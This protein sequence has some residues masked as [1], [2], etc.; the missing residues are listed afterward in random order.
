MS[1]H[2]N[3]PPEMQRL[4]LFVGDWTLAAGFGGEPSGEPLGRARFEWALGDQYV[5]EKSTVDV[6]E[7]P[8]GLAVMAWH[9]HENRYVQH[10][11]DSAA[12]PACTRWNSM[13]GSGSF[14]AETRISRRSPSTSATKASS[15]T[16]AARLTDT[17]TSRSLARNGARTSI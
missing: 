12:L 2:D 1:D 10:Y 5:I 7:A 4:A 13:A 14:S 11:F 17:G 3:T 9:P 6:P 16:T 15:H 8:D